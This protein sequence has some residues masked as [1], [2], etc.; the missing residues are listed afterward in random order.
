MSNPHEDFTEM[1]A[2]LLNSLP[3]DVKQLLQER[4]MPP[5]EEIAPEELPR[6][7]KETLEELQDAKA[8]LAL[9][10]GQGEAT[11][12]LEQEIEEMQQY[13]ARILKR[14]EEET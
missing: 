10:K 1:I 12:E 4:Y 11:Q 14:L 3:E 6:A 2:D 9:L 5:V 7:K 13:L 8:E